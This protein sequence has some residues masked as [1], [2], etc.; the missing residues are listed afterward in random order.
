[1][2]GSL[3]VGVAYT[4]CC[5][6]GA[7]LSDAPECATW[8]YD[9]GITLPSPCVPWLLPLTSNGAAVIVSG[10]ALMIYSIERMRRILG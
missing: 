2:T 4:N 10:M 5:T 7:P 6:D 8:N 1:M 9:Y 3:M